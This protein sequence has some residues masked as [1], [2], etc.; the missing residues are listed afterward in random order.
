MTRIL[1]I[2]CTLASVAGA[3]A[4]EVAFREAARLEASIVR[5]GD[6]ADIR[7][8][9]PAERDRL[10]NL[11]LMP[12]PAPGEVQHVRSHAIR[13][14]LKAHGEPLADHRFT[15]APAI[16][17]RRDIAPRTKTPIASKPWRGA[18]AGYRS[19][20][21]STTTT[22]PKR[23]YLITS[24]D[25]A[26]AKERV[27]QAITGWLAEQP[28]DVAPRGVVSVAVT[29]RQVVVIER[30]ARRPL[31]VTPIDDAD[32]HSRF[33][34]TTADGGPLDSVDVD[35][36]LV[37]LRRAIVA[38]TSIARGDL[39]TASRVALRPLPIED[40]KRVGNR[41]LFE[42]L[43]SVLGNEASRAIREGE[44]LT[45]ANCVSPILVRRG[46]TVT[47]V[48]GGGGVSVKLTAIARGDGRSGDLVTVEA[49]DRD[50]RFDARVVGR[51]RL[52]I[53]SASATDARLATRNAGGSR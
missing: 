16:A 25:R 8:N 48:S 27:R 2:A 17:V 37:T 23:R 24:R 18:G 14:L 43:E 39:I 31:S 20:A 13:D 21:P 15:G 50:E 35:A 26:A 3:S 4:A 6:V 46:E 12:T 53:V 47:V 34:I 10:A 49:Y 29:D 19:V 44:P 9:D 30:F 11:P 41:R 45:G 5:L 36:E 51:G 38:T 28:E 42:D 52:A 40:A 33:R 7:A 22:A 32:N 1:T